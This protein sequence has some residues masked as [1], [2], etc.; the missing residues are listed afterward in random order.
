MG[1]QEISDLDTSPVVLHFSTDGGISW[2]FIA[3]LTRDYQ[4]IPGLPHT[5]HYT[6]DI[7]GIINLV[8]LY[9]IWC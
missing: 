2:T 8:I 3:E 9:S 5:R 6:L 7:P 4:T 1:H